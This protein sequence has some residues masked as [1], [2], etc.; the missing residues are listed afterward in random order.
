MALEREREC[1][2]CW[3]RQSKWKHSPHQR[4]NCRVQEWIQWTQDGS[5][6]HV[7]HLSLERRRD[8]WGG[9]LTIYTCG[10]IAKGAETPWILKIPVV[11]SGWLKG[12]ASCKVK[13]CQKIEDACCWGYAPDSCSWLIFLRWIERTTWKLKHH[14][15]VHH[16]ALLWLIHCMLHP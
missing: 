8:D 11:L 15:A 1:L 2:S 13:L 10:E 7:C 3:N 9:S 16:P 14:G 4:S 5:H 6:W 12:K